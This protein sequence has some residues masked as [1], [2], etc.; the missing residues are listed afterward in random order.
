LAGLKE[1]ELQSV[2]S[3][4]LFLLPSF[5]RETYANRDAAVGKKAQDIIQKL[6][7]EGLILHDVSHFF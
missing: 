1:K 6:K 3:A 5:Q 4:L 2:V 7:M